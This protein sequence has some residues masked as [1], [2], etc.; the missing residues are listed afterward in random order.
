MSF[1]G[2]LNEQEANEMQALINQ[3]FSQIE[4]NWK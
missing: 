4:G 2:T 1:A 3:E